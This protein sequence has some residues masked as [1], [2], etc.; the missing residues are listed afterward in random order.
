MIKRLHLYKDDGNI[1]HLVDVANLA[2]CEF[3]EGHN[4]GRQLTPMDDHNHHTRTLS[5]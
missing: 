5:Q 3:E 2:L 4:N 1:E